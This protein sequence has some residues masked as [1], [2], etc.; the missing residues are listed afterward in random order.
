MLA[1]TVAY[2]RRGM[3]EFAEN[4]WAF[5]FPI[6]AY[7]TSTIHLHLHHTEE[8][9]LLYYA[10]FLYALTWLFYSVT[11]VLSVYHGYR[12]WFGHTP[13]EETPT[14]AKPPYEDIVS[15][16]PGSKDKR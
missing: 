11:T 2:L 7:S 6:A 4:W 8:S 10:G 3:M 5:V 14:L 16:A 15:E 1:V 12:K 13:G 9:W